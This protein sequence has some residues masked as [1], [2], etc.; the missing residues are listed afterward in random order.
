[1]DPDLDFNTPPLLFED[2]SEAGK[3]RAGVAVAC[4]ACK[5]AKKRCD[6]GR[7]CSRCVRLGDATSCV[8]SIHSKPG[9]KP[10]PKVKRKFDEDEPTLAAAHKLVARADSMNAKALLRTPLNQLPLG[11]LTSLYET[12]APSFAS[13]AELDQI[14]AVS[15]STMLGV[16][17]TELQLTSPKR[18]GPMQASEITETIRQGY[19][20]LLSRMRALSQAFASGQTPITLP[21]YLH[22]CSVLFQ[23]SMTQHIPPDEVVRH[24]TELW[25]PSTD[26]LVSMMR[27]PSEPL[28]H[29][30]D[31][32]T[33]VGLP[34]GVMQ[35]QLVGTDA[36][37]CRSNQPAAL[38]FGYGID[39]LNRLVTTPD[40]HFFVRHV[41]AD[42]WRRNIPYALQTIMAQGREGV[43]RAR[44]LTAY[45][46]TIE[47]IL[48]SRY[49]Y[50]DGLLIQHT[51]FITRCDIDNC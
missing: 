22:M 43:Y 45:G 32:P 20:G 44:L 38:I 49:M 35:M 48:T 4:V 29:N 19:F 18:C 15:Y 10:G 21:L 30:D 27:S 28:I 34:L 24:R 51:L 50:H 2:F 39:E 41:H 1:M 33:L 46:E 3:A 25:L 11:E 47:T 7:P 31:W 12:L 5:I 6:L 8:D 9:R 40:E 37:N 26:Q 42:D 13:A 23:P 16:S 36:V 14:S 17:D